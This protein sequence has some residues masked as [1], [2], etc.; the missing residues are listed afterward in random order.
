MK[1]STEKCS[2]K[3]MLWNKGVYMENYGENSRKIPV[4]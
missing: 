2:E 3:K 1:T 4:R